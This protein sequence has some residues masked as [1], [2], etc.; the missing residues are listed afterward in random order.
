MMSKLLLILVIIATHVH[1]ESKV[2]VNDNAYACNL[3]RIPANEHA[4]SQPD[5]RQLL[6]MQSYG[7]TAKEELSLGD[8][9]AVQC[10]ESITRDDASSNALDAL[11]EIHDVRRIRLQIDAE[12]SIS[13]QQAMSHLEPERHVFMVRK[14]PEARTEAHTDTDTDSRTDSQGNKGWD[15]DKE[16]TSLVHTRIS[17]TEEAALLHR[18]H[19]AEEASAGRRAAEKE[20]LEALIAQYDQAAAAGR[21][22]ASAAQEAKKAAAGGEL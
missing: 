5:C 20:R 15:S 10:A 22:A 9:F 7:L 8:L 19:S 1:S 3:C 6:P 4:A 17:H 13:L 16:L 18:T 12:E 11:S 14:T 2:I 21:A